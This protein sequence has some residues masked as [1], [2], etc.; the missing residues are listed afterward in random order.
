M[1]THY[2]CPSEYGIPKI[3]NDTL[4]GSFTLTSSIITVGVG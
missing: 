2:R 1:Q 4:L 3:R